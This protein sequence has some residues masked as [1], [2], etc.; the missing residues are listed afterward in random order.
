MTAAVAMASSVSQTLRTT[1]TRVTRLRAPKQAQ[2]VLSA[3]GDDPRDQDRV[4]HHERHSDES[5]EQAEP[6][7]EQRDG[8]AEKQLRPRV[9]PPQPLPAKYRGH[10]E[11]LPSGEG[12]GRA[13]LCD[14]ARDEDGREHERDRDGQSDGHRPMLVPRR[15]AGADALAVPVPAT[16]RE[17]PA[18]AGPSH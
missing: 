14:A 13:E 5:G 4:A 8:C 10:T 7:A 17:G 2:D 3:P 11:L 12:V 9:N 1:V 16:G 18:E 15:R 6:A